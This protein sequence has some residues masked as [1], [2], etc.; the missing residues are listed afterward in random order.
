MALPVI[1]RCPWTRRIL[2][3]CRV[4]TPWRKSSRKLHTCRPRQQRPVYYDRLLMTCQLSRHLLLELAE[5]RGFIGLSVRVSRRTLVVVLWVL[6]DE[7]AVT[8]KQIKL[9]APLLHLDFAGVSVLL[10]PTSG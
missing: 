8:M 4:Q 10:E 5:Q 1:Q 3:T 6:L 7:Y 2:P 9:D